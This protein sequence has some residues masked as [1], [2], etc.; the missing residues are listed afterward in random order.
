MLWL[1]LTLVL[2]V[3]CVHLPSV[4]LEL[5]IHDIVAPAHHFG[6]LDS[7]LHVWE[8]HL[9]I[10]SLGVKE[11]IGGRGPLHEWRL[12]S[13]LSVELDDPVF[14]H[15]L[16]SGMVVDVL[17]LRHIDACNF[18]LVSLIVNPWIS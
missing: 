7:C 9:H 1:W 13:T 2:E 10:V 4:I 11:V 15:G 16:I 18:V 14:A 5:W 17:L 6:I 12:E 8:P 3:F